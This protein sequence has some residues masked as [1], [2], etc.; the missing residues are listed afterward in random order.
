M[1]TRRSKCAGLSNQDPVLHLEIKDGRSACGRDLPADGFFTDSESMFEERE[2]SRC[3]SCWRVYKLLVEK[4]DE[5]EFDKPEAK[6]A[7]EAAGSC[8]T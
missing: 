8:R 7:R 1:T 3:K 5:A 4:Q 2:G 6:A